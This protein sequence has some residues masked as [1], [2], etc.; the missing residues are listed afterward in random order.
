MFVSVCA[1]LYKF[2]I[3]WDP[4]SKP[5]K[6]RDCAPWY[7]C[8]CASER[9][10][11][12]FSGFLKIT[13]HLN[14]HTIWFHPQTQYLGSPCKPSKKVALFNNGNWLFWFI[15][16][17]MLFISIQNQ[18]VKLHKNFDH[19]KYSLLM[20]MKSFLLNWIFFVL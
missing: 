10:K 6:T 12:K 20:N 5:F 17:S 11:L 18:A 1:W 2:E 4:V 14:S 8:K 9:E 19:F 7:H 3:I 16:V 15:V 13:L